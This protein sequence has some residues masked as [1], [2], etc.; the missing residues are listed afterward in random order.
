MQD[1]ETAII[2]RVDVCSSDEYQ[3]SSTALIQCSIWPSEV[4][5]KARSCCIV[6]RTLVFVFLIY[7]D[8]GEL[9]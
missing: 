6:R 4:A 9:A 5:E 2:M 8:K 1:V 7:A 3:G